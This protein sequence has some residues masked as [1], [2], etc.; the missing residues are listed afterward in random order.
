MSPCHTWS[1]VLPFKTLPPRALEHGHLHTPHA[2]G[3]QWKRQ[4]QCNPQHKA[5]TLRVMATADTVEAEQK[6]QRRREKERGRS[7]YSPQSYKE[8][9]QDAVQ[10][11]EYAL[12]DNV[13][14]MEVD[15]PTLSGDSKASHNVPL[16]P[17]GCTS[18]LPFQSSNESLSCSWNKFI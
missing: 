2:Q 7:T 18:C 4:L 3:G 9:L 15:F 11:I 13:K 8:L 14:R 12:E 1:R 17:R 10:S 6:S 5:H 16:Q